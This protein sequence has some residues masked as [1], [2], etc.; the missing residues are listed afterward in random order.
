MTGNLDNQSLQC[1]GQAALR[2][3][4]EDASCWTW[5]VSKTR[6]QGSK[7]V[8]WLHD[9][10]MTDTVCPIKASGSQIWQLKKELNGRAVCTPTLVL[11]GQSP[12]K[13][14]LSCTWECRDP[15]FPCSGSATYDYL[16]EK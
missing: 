8:D 14:T 11:D 1:T 16:K 9:S 15:A 10:D 6:C 13:L 7:D 5:E 12:V 4:T 3:D 2:K